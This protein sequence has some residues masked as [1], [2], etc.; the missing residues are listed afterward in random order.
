MRRRGCGSLS[1]CD[2][3]GGLVEAVELE[4][5]DHSLPLDYERAVGNALHLLFNGRVP[6]SIKQFDDALSL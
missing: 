4:W 3:T 6:S 1:V 2:A 5:L